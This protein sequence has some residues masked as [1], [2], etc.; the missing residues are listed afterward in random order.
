MSGARFRAS[1]FFARQHGVVSFHQLAESGIG[2]RQ[3]EHL[4]ERGEFV[5]FIRGVYRTPS[6]PVTELSRCAAVCLAHPR[7]VVAGPTAGRLWGFRSLTRDRRVH[8]LAPRHYRASKADW[9]TA[10]RTD[11]LSRHDV[12]ERADGIRLTHRARTALDLA[13]HLR[14]DDALLSVIEQAAHEGRLRDGDLRAVVPASPFQRAH[15]R[16]FLAQLD[17][18]LAGG[19]AESEPEVRVGEALREAGVVG[20]ERQFAVDL[21]GYGHARFDLALPSQLWALEVDVFPTH[22]EML[23][24]ERDRRRDEAAAIV[25]WTV[26]RISA[27]QYERHFDRTIADIIS[28]LDDHEAA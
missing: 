12:C 3:I 24:R 22:S 7:V 17:R 19:A 16:R 4:I 15:V 26:R 1:E 21:P 2:R 18:R 25:G 5:P 20:L 6:V 23:G 10:Y 13:R 28:S 14:S 9:C 27:T 8:V 11:V